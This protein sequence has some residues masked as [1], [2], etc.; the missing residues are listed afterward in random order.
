L[1]IKEKKN[2]EN[3]ATITKM[4]TRRELARVMIFFLDN[5]FLQSHRSLLKTS[6]EV[7]LIAI[8]LYHF[9]IIIHFM[10]NYIKSRSSFIIM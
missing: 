10:I 3:L 9:K 8:K 1:E 4:D 2:K 5:H 7:I 6:I